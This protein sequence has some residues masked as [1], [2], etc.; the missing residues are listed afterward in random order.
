MSD[1]KDHKTCVH[2]DKVLPERIDALD[3]FGGLCGLCDGCRAWRK[4]HD[5]ELQKRI[6]TQSKAASEEALKTP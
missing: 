6:L 3:H 4:T 5:A 1:Q 2:C